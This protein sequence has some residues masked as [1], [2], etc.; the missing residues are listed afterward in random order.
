M[1]LYRKIPS[2]EYRGSHFKDK[3]VPRLASGIWWQINPRHHN[4]VTWVTRCLKSESTRLFVQASDKETHELRITSRLW[5]KSTT[6]DN[7]IKWRHFPRNWPFVRGIHRSPVN[8]PHKGRWRGALMLSLICARINGR[9]NNVEA[10]D[11]RRYRA[12][13]DVIVMGRCHTQRSSNVESFSM[14]SSWIAHNTIQKMVV[15]EFFFC[16]RDMGFGTGALWDLWGSQFRQNGWLFNF[17]FYKISSISWIVVQNKSHWNL[18][19]W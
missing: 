1:R 16:S 15:I 2:Q 5:G 9:V 4:N 14:T 12:H 7:V 10:G 8:C 6:H 3:T 19:K 18:A 13:C 11:L 17:I